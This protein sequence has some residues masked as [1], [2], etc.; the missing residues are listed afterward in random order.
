MKMS[1]PSEQALTF[2]RGTTPLVCA[3]FNNRFNITLIF[4]WAMYFYQSLKECQHSWP[5]FL[6]A[7][8]RGA[9]QRQWQTGNVHH[10]QQDAD[11]QGLYL[12]QE[13]M[14]SIM[15]LKCDFRY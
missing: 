15:E 13:K 8:G 4:S 1:S 7:E 14:F 6:R 5:Y 11:L 10:E 2:I 3:D 9:Y 12:V